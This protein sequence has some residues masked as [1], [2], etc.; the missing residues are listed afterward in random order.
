MNIFS[1]SALDVYAAFSM[2]VSG[3]AMILGIYNLVNGIVMHRFEKNLG[4]GA[5]YVLVVVGAAI[6]A[7]YYTGI[8]FG[9]LESNLGAQFLRPANIFVFMGVILMLV[10]GIAIDRKLEQLEEKSKSL[11]DL[12]KRV[13]SG[14]FD[15]IKKGKPPD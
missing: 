9:F 5:S 6:Y 15:G 12:R 8:S 1:Q 4:R 11:E 10:D 3:V 14:D 13:I 7:F 2:A